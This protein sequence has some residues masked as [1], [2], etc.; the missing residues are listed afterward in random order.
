MSW[1]LNFAAVLS[2]ALF[3]GVCVLW[4][5]SYRVCDMWGTWR[6]GRSTVFRSVRGE[7]RWARLSRG[8]V[9]FDWPPGYAS[10]PAAGV[11]PSS[12]T[13]AWSFAGFRWTD[14]RPSPPDAHGTRLRTLAIPDWSLLLATAALPLL[15]FLNRRSRP[16]PGL[17]AACGYDLRATPDV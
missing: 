5:R 13:P 16:R 12:L 8:S 4:V 1:A 9:T 6:P 15:R 17:C 11:R 3:V 14:F 10:M 2:G 7:M